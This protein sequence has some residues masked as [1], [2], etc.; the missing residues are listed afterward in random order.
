MKRWFD[1]KVHLRDL[2]SWSGYTIQKS[3]GTRFDPNIRRSPEER[4]CVMLF[5]L[6]CPVW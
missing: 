2:G 1:S 5:S 3:P 6:G 4:A